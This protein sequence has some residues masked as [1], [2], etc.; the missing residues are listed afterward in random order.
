MAKIVIPTP[1][2]KFTDQQREYEADASTVKES[3]DQLTEAYPDLAENLL[4][5]DG[6]IRSYVRIYIGDD[7]IGDLENGATEVDEDTVISIVP[8]IAG[9]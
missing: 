9:G 2:R 7:E 1:L 4:D 5:D 8:A 3:L 6:N